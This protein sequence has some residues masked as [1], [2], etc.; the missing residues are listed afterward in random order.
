MLHKAK[1]PLLEMLLDLCNLQASTCA[2]EATGGNQ[3]EAAKLLLEN[4]SKQAGFGYPR[5][6]SIGTWTL[7]MCQL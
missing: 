4:R 1:S 6:M 5:D 2:L 7:K 3:E